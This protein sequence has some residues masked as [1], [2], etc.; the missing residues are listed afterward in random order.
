MLCQCIR[1]HLEHGLEFLAHPQITVANKIHGPRILFIPP[2][3]WLRQWSWNLFLLNIRC[4]RVH[5]QGYECLFQYL[6][7]GDDDEGRGAGVGKLTSLPYRKS[8]PWKP[9]KNSTRKPEFSW[10]FSVDF[11]CMERMSADMSTFLWMKLLQ[12]EVLELQ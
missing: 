1:W 3:M 6:L 11:F 8:R 10:V 12:H 5:F 2:I 4:R 9:E 7:G